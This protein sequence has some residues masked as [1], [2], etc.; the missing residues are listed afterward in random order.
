MYRCKTCGV[1]IDEYQYNNYN[2]VC[3]NCI[4][5]EKGSSATTDVGRAIV[6]QNKIKANQDVLG[7]MGGA[8]FVCLILTIFGLFTIF[9]MGVIG[10]VVLVL[11]IYGLSKV[12]KKRV[13]LKEEL[14]KLSK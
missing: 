6:L 2:G 3:S 14:S 5:I 1:E 12:Y 9:V 8:T 11:L 10:I 13:E 4:R 7:V